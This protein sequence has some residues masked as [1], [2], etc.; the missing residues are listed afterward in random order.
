MIPPCK[1]CITLPICK[2]RYEQD[3]IKFPDVT[4]S[5]GR[6]P[7]YIANLKNVCPLVK[8][9]LENN[10]PYHECLLSVLNIL[11]SKQPK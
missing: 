3:A 1:D 6:F 7:L 11:E 8:D 2:S 5:D 10:N 4:I 9:Y